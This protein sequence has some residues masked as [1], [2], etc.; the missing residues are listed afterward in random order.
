[1]CALP[2]TARP[3]GPKADDASLT[4]NDGWAEVTNAK[5]VAIPAL[6]D[7][8]MSAGQVLR[9]ECRALTAEPVTGGQPWL[10]NTAVSANMTYVKPI[11]PDDVA[12]EFPADAAVSNNAD[13]GD[14]YHPHPAPG[15]RPPTIRRPR[16]T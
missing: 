12:P 16:T 7:L 4:L 9:V 1:M 2:S 6:S 11:P 5:P 10:F 3:S 14:R 8:E 15:P 13:A